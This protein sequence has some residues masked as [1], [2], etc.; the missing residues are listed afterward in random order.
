L[1]KIFDKEKILEK[2]EAATL[3]GEIG[4]LMIETFLMD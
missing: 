1:G 4:F 2:Q 3:F